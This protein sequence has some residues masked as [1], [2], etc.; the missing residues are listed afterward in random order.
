MKESTKEYFRNS[1]SWKKSIHLIASFIIVTTICL[2][3][4][5]LKVKKSN[6]TSIRLAKDFTFI[7]GITLLSY[8]GLMWILEMG[9]GLSLFKGKNNKYN[10]ENDII[11]KLEEEKKKPNSEE[12]QIRVKILNEQLQEAKQERMQ[13]ENKKRYNFVLVLI[14]VIAILTLITAGILQAVK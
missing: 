2:V 1:F 8:S 11:R 9:F 13:K 6:F 3:Y 5:F 4:Y 12:K 10:R 7:I 14:A